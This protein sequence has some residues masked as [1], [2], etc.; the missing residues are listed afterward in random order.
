MPV[1]LLDDFGDAS[2]WHAFTSGE[3]TLGLAH[4]RSDSDGDA[5]RLDFD[6]KGGG[7]FVVARKAF[8]L[9]LP[10]TWT[11]TLHLRGTAGSNRL[12]VKL[13]APDDRNVWW[14]RCD[15]FTPSSQGTVVR[16]PSRE[17]SFAWGPG[18]GGAPREVG[19][20]EIAIVAGSGGR[21]TWQL[22]R[23]TLEDRTPAAPPA[24][25]ASSAM[26][27]HEPANA[28]DPDPARD[29]RSDASDCEPWLA[30]DFGAPREYGGFVIAW[31]DAG[32]PRAFDVQCSEDGSTWRTLCAVREAGGERS[33]VAVPGGASSRSVRFVLREP[34]VRAAGVA[35]R[36]LQVRPLDFSRSQA[37]FLHAVAA[38]E[39]RGLYPRWLYREQSYWT[40][41][42][43]AGNASA[44]LLSEDGLFEPDF[45]SFSIEPFLFVDGALVSW[46]DVERDVSLAE[47]RLPI[48]SVTW[49]VPALELVVTAFAALHEGVPAAHCRYEVRNAGAAPRDVRLFLALRPLQVTPPWQSSGVVGGVAPIRALAWRDG[50]VTVDGNTRVLPLTPGAA[51]GAATF[52]EGGALRFLECGAVP[53][54]AAIEDEDGL[55]SGALRWDLEP[56]PGRNAVLEIA[57]PFGARAP[58]A[59]A[60]NDARDAPTSL[61]T[62]TDGWRRKLARP[63]VTLGGEPLDC[64]S[65]LHTAIAHVLVARDGAALQPGPR[66]YARSWIRDAA[67]MCA[68][69]LRAGC[70][71]EVEDFLAW[72]ATHQREDGSVP[73]AF[74][75]AGADPLVEHDSH[76][77][78]ASALVE[79]ARFVADRATGRR[80]W[81]FVCRAVAHIESLRATRC[82]AEYSSGERRN[83]HGLL[84]ESV[85]HE[86]Y[87]AQPVHSYWDDFWALRGIADA[88]HLSHVVADGAEADRL[89]VLRDELAAS[90]AA[91]VRQ[92]IGA[93]GIEHVPASVEWADLDPA[94]TAMAICSSFGERCLPAEAL[95]RTFDAYMAR[96]RERRRA[97]S[98]WNNYSAYEV[99]IAPALV[100]LGRREDAWEVL[101]FILGD[102][103]PRAWNQWPE[104]SWQDP[105][106]PGHLGDLP[107]AWIAAEYALA[108]MTM[109]AYEDAASEAL[110]IAAGVPASWFEQGEL[111]VAGLAS[112]WGPLDY[113]LRRVGAETIALELNTRLREPP[114]G[115]VVRPPLPRPLRAVEVDASPWDDFDDASVRLRSTPARVTLAF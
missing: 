17:V 43:L 93:R 45:A 44:A 87:L 62:A 57:V 85:S 25:T 12:E 113:R 33:Y 92:V 32:A 109:L 90:I 55:A 5:L 35:V 49:R 36:S 20:I 48:P 99:R 29:W 84:P 104:I 68:A 59:P 30:L 83:R 105:R 63:Q 106:S 2:G 107:H 41:V 91:S 7:G 22:S 3:A 18:G 82:T 86:G 97:G 60:R 51:F 56:S 101:Q 78:L 19:A 50:G 13:V 115:V 6:F 39:R 108:V 114:G 34:P 1:A 103:R 27:G 31:G 61:A 89:A 58:L 69:L 98:D 38:G 111:H 112:W 53:P 28:L 14:W 66:R 26:P 42:S 37:D 21:G 72:Y 16:I 95:H 73:C 47:G 102:R 71:A 94:A 46:T 100:R 110:V 96:L 76:G 23:I 81:P 80:W 77:Q 9:S 79:H 4:E 74:G 75:R 65:A 8:R 40:P 64:V 70:I 11:L 15:A 88:V 67:V 24:V 10:E 52:A 54:R